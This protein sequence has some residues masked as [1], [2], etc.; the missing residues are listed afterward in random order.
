VRM[1]VVAAAIA[2]MLV[3]AARLVRHR[4]HAASRPSLIADDDAGWTVTPRLVAGPRLIVRVRGA[5]A[6]LFQ[7]DVERAGRALLHDAALVVQ[8]DG[9]YAIDVPAAGAGAYD[10][11]LRGFGGGEHYAG[12][13]SLRC[14]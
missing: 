14:P 9:T 8:G 3:G 1:I 7:V 5:N 10:V 6:P 11:D 4:H 2:M 12:H 13:W